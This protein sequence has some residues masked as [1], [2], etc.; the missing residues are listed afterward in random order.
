MGPVWT[1]HPLPCS[2]FKVLVLERRPRKNKEHVG[3][4]PVSL[5]G[6]VGGW[7]EEASRLGWAEGLKAGARTYRSSLGAEPITVQ[8]HLAPLIKERE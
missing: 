6:G 8:V 5:A 4:C 7:L 3:S 2:L 1:L